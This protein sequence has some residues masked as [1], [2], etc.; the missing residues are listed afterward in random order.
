M[1][2]PRS[3]R[4][5]VEL[6]REDATGELHCRQRVLHGGGAVQLEIHVALQADRDQRRDVHEERIRIRHGTA[7]RAATA[8]L[9]RHRAGGVGDGV[10]VSA[11]SSLS[12]PS[13]DVGVRSRRRTGRRLRGAAR[14]GEPPAT[15]GAGC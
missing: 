7:R 5:V 10:G 11:L 4:L 12:S 2:F 9:Q 6:Q 8:P 14:C 3:V 13:D 1:R 15:E